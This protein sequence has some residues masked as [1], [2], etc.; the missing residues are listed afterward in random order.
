MSNNS[1]RVEELLQTLTLEEKVGLLAGASMWYTVPV[2]RLGI[3]AIKVSDGPNGARGDVFGSGKSAACFPAGISLASTWDVDLIAEVG[4]ALAE[5]AR[6]KG[7][8]VLLGPTVNIHRSPLNGRNFECFSEDPYLTS[9]MAVAYIT[10]LQRGGVGAAVKHYAGNNSEFERNTISSEIGER[11]FR[12]IYL[13]AFE[14]AVREAGTWLVMSAYNK[15]NGTYCGENPGLLTG[16]LKEEWGWEGAVVSDWFGTHSTAPAANAGL[17]LEMPGPT[18]WRSEKLV[19]AV[20]NGEVSE[21]VIDAAAARILHLIERTGAFEQPQIHEE[22]SIDRLEHRAVIRRAGAEGT[23]L[24]QN[25]D[26]LLPLDPGALRSVAIIGPNAKVAQI[27]GGGSAHVHAHYAIT[28]YEGIVAQLGSTIE[29]GYEPGADNHKFAPALDMSRVAP[30]PGAPGG[31]FAVEYFNN[32]DLSGAPEVKDSLTGSEPIWLGEVAPGVDLRAFSA[33]ISGVYTP[34]ESGPYTFG[35]ASS[36]LSRLYV[37]GK[38]IIDNWTEQSSGASFMGMGSAE[39]LAEVNLQAGKPVALR[40]EY[41]NLKSTMLA[42]VRLGAAPSS[43]DDAI[44]RAAALAKRSDV[45]LVFVGSSGEWESEGVDR[46]NM[47]LS[48]KQAEL[49]EAVAAANP[50]TVVVLQTGSPVAMPWLAAP[51]AVLQA[52]FCGQECGNSIADVL[53]GKVDATGR[54]P[55]TFPRR[56]QDN[57]AYINYPGENGKVVYGEGIFVGYRYYDKKEIDPLFP[58]GF[59]LSYTTFDYDNLIVSPATS[60][61]GETVRVSVDVRNSGSRDGTEIVQLY[62]RDVH[63]NVLR[64]EKELKGFARVQ[65]KAGESRTVTLSLDRRAFAYYS[66]A[67]RQWIAEAGDF[68]LMVGRSAGDIRLSAPFHLTDTAAFDGPGRQAARLSIESTI[69]ELLT[70]NATRAILDRHLPGFSTN[71]QVGFAQ[72]FSLAQLAGFDSETFN[73]ATLLA[74]AADLQDAE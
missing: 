19:Q 9:R 28:P 51:A 47:D 63:S 39:K 35:L 73:E 41:S 38:E 65:L 57:P 72:G 8:S 27:M 42:G 10:G 24:L 15:F 53:F 13:P 37:D 33:R 21:A 60:A 18:Q 74:I 11:A 5:E 23:V 31:K 46:P 7:A 1:K 67:A 58:F 50:R 32:Q 29:I 22:Q 66:E 54:L 59:G 30:S 12:E 56:L 20:R 62:V 36:G 64:P 14:A 68:Q 6:T 48:G 69:K 61:P 43:R 44:E 4:N 55:Q 2:E 40:V 26:N 25:R 52:W 71:P 17:D 16:I 70:D 34:E 3:P 45:A 49:I